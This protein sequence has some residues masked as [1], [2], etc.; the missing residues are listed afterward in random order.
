MP[1]AG[2]QNQGRSQMEV[3]LLNGRTF[4][5]ES[6]LQIPQRLI[7]FYLSEARVIA[8]LMIG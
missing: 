3:G 1:A 5:L 8:N 2:A 7:F 6:L 4:L